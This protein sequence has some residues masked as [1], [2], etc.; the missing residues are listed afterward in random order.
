[1]LNAYSLEFY[2]KL[3]VFSLFALIDRLFIL[4][5]FEIM[6][7]DTYFS[8]M[9]IIHDLPDFPFSPRVSFSGMRYASRALGLG[10]HSF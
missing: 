8:H 10:H 1:M 6:F 3:G 7:F 2:R 5:L 9:K 4:K